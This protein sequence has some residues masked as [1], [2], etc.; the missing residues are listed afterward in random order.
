MV[1]DISIRISRK[2]SSIRHVDFCLRKKER[3]DPLKEDAKLFMRKKNSIDPWRKSSLLC[4]SLENKEMTLHEENAARDAPLEKQG[5]SIG[6]KGRDIC[7]FRKRKSIT[8][9][10]SLPVVKVAA[11]IHEEIA[12]LV[13]NSSSIHETKTSTSFRIVRESNPVL[14]E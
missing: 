1:K 13:K 6:K 11:L 3:P 4:I 5:T 7:A 2:V 14:R 9:R 10:C 8:L 12:L